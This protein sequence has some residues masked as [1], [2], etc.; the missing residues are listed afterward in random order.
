[1]KPDEKSDKVADLHLHTTASDGT[2]TVEERIRQAKD[3]GLDAIAIT[4]HDSIPEEL[5]QPARFEEGL[6][7]IAGTEL[8]AEIEGVKIEILGYYVDPTNTSLQKD[9]E[10]LQGYRRRRNEKMTER[11]VDETGVDVTYETLRQESQG[12]VGRPE[13]AR[14]LVRE[15]KAE[16]VSEA[17]DEYLGEDGDVYLPIKKKRYTEVIDAIHEAGGVA[18]LAHPGRID[19]EE[20]P[21]YVAEMA[22]YGLDGIEVWYTYNG[23]KGVT[24]GVGVEEASNLAEEHGLLR[25]GGSDCHGSESEK[26]YIGDT[27]VPA[28]ELSGLK[29]TVDSLSGREP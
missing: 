23:R 18:S 27:G 13:F 10:E 19:S 16:T 22:E 9:L 2:D 1:M 24:S 25:T 26:F 11:F 17:F 21:R 3:R 5:K 20:V 4:D 8:K 15:G 12:Q 29:N 28:G 6:E 14:L 7:L